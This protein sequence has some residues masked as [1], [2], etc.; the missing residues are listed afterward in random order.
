MILREKIQYYL[1]VSGLYRL[2]HVTD[3]FT[4]AWRLTGFSCEE[5]SFIKVE[6]NYINVECFN[7][8]E[9]GRVL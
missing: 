7:C 9:R 8:Y 6:E 2:K 3:A 1:Y 4:L 5:L